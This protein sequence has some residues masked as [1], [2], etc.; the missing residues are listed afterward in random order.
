MT[1]ACSLPWARY[2][3]PALQLPAEAHD[4]E[5]I[6]AYWPPSCHTPWVPPVPATT[7]YSDNAACI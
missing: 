6:R 2:W 7:G 1:N 4:T 3:P 5:M